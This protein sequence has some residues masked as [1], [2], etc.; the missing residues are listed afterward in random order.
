MILTRT[1]GNIA[2]E[3]TEGWFG[4]DIGEKFFTQ[5]VVGH[6]KRLP[7]EAVE[8]PSL[9]LFQGQTGGGFEQPGVGKVFLSMVRGAGTEWSLRSF[10]P[11]AF[12]DS[13]ISIR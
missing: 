12:C 11:Q 8:E 9:G 2:L 5:R 10:P 7:R 1:K 6:W 13:I 3:L 4:F